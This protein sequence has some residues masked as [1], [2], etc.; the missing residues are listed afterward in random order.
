[1]KAAK[2]QAAKEISWL[3]KARNRAQD[4]CRMNRIRES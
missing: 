1:L 3:S 2:Q 4:F